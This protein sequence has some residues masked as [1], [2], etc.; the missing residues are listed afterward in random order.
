[1][2]CLGRFTVTLAMFSLA[3]RVFVGYNS[4]LKK[5]GSFA[6]CMSCVGFFGAILCL[7]LKVSFQR[8]QKAVKLLVL[9]F[10]PLSPSINPFSMTAY[11]YSVLDISLSV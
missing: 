7:I 11:L 6:V 2:S 5:K 1:M 4:I 9:L 10:L 8:N 3:L